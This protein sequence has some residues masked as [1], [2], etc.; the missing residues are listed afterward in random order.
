[1]SSV[2]ERSPEEESNADFK[3]S[4]W[5]CSVLMLYFSIL[6]IGMRYFDVLPVFLGG[7]S[8]LAVIVILILV[9][10]AIFEQGYWC[11]SETEEVVEGAAW[12]TAFWV[13]VFVL[14]SG[15]GLLGY[16]PR[17]ISQWIFKI[18]FP[19]G[20]VIIVLSY[21]NDSWVGFSKLGFRR[22][23][24]E[25]SIAYL[26][27]AVMI[28]LP[29]LWGA[30]LENAFTNRNLMAWIDFLITTTLFP[31]VG[32]E[33][34]FRGVLQEGLRRKYQ[35]RLTGLVLAS[36][37]F[38]II[39]IFTNQG[40]NSDIILGFALTF[41]MQFIGGIVLGAVYESTG[42]LYAPILIHYLHNA[43]VWIIKIPEMSSVSLVYYRSSFILGVSTIAIMY[44][45]SRRTQI[46]RSI[47][48]MY[49]TLRR[50]LSCMKKCLERE[51]C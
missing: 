36:L 9:T 28:F 45:W 29:Y 16:V 24:V 31:A 43:K 34:V 4:P 10:P 50:I 37:A 19:V 20:V 25:R 13:T 21:N 38:G 32:E 1:M 12:P 33:I 46:S 49:A 27:V 22:G 41:A 5:L 8:V 51:I 17:P 11:R 14:T 39:H 23:C 26:I 18:L 44:L 48:K 6:L 2:E 7:A 47:A 35:N 40:D 42:S 30:F 3:G 15:C